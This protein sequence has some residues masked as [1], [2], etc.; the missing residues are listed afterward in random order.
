[1]LTPSDTYQKLLRNG[2]EKIKFSEAAGRVTGVMLVPYPPGIPVRMPGE[3]LGGPS[4]PTV[5]MIL[6]LQEFGKRFPGFER[7]V[8]GIENDAQG[9]FWVRV[10]T[11]PQQENATGEVLG[12]VR[13]N[14][15][16]EKP[17]SSAP[18]VKKRRVR[19][20]KSATTAS[21]TK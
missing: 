14:G 19:P 13:A 2:T 7:E 1:V 17:P 15:R 5:K 21:G 12:T 4:S 11:E 6:A 8:H 18:P 10:I 20:A 9:D 16:R 3:R